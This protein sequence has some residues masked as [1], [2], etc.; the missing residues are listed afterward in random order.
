VAHKVKKH[1]ETR[2]LFTLIVCTENRPL[3]I[4]DK[5]IDIYE[6]TNGAELTEIKEGAYKY[7]Q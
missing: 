5:L 7:E 2:S 1:S 6:Y 4:E 3:I